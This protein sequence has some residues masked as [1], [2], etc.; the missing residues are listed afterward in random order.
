MPVPRLPEMSEFAAGEYVWWHPVSGLFGGSSV[1]VRIVNEESPDEHGPRYKVA[2]TTTR[3]VLRKIVPESEL[4]R[5]LV[6]L[7]SSE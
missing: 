1:S 5:T 6:D 7:A 3:A 4:T 2:F